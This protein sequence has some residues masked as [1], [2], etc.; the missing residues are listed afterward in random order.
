M[1]KNLSL[2]RLVCIVGLIYIAGQLT[3]NHYLA[4]RLLSKKPPAAMGMGAALSASVDSLE[5]QISDR[6]AYEVKPVGD[7]LNLGRVLHGSSSAAAGGNEFT[8]GRQQ[9]RLSCTILSEKRS[10]AIIKVQGRSYVVAAGDTICGMS[11]GAIDAKQVS[12][13]DHGRTVVLIN[14]PAS[15]SEISTQARREAQELRL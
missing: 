4:R 8:E 10:T 7:P 13:L 2:L 15:Q 5:Q 1:D 14:E 3:A 12:L 9:M 6:L 11:V